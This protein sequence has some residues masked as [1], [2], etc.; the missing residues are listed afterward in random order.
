[1]ESAK[2]EHGYVPLRVS[3][4]RMYLFN[5]IQTDA[6]ISIF[7]YAARDEGVFIRG[8]L[9]VGFIGIMPILQTLVI[10]F[11]VQERGTSP[12][13]LHYIRSKCGT[14]VEAIVP[15]PEVEMFKLGWHRFQLTTPKSNDATPG[16]LCLLNW[17]GFEA[18]VRKTGQTCSAQAKSPT[19][20]VPAFPPVASGTHPSGTY[21]RP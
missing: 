9:G 20:R 10:R 11:I 14:K 12:K 18:V 2:E 4:F 17:K 3:W 15:W 5:L 21:V 13:G 16:K 1:M 7:L 19:S 6:F 8:I